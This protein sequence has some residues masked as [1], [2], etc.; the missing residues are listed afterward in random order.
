MLVERAG[1]S[2]GEAR[3][4]DPAFMI[5][6][7]GQSRDAS[8]GELP[9]GTVGRGRGRTVVHTAIHSAWQVGDCGGK[10]G[11]RQTT[12]ASPTEETQ[13]GIRLLSLQRAEKDRSTV[14]A[15]S[16]L[17]FPNR[18]DY[19]RLRTIFATS[20]FSLISLFI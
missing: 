13:E 19:E 10:T 7:W 15:H 8:L 4:G 16:Q 3:C 9:F 2:W 20:L 18:S 1:R 17:C 5:G 11:A 12:E 14:S 6:C